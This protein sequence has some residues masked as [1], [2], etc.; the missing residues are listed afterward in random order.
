M[1]FEDYPMILTPKE[2][3]DILN[4]SKDKVYRLFRSRSFLLRKSRNVHNPKAKISEM[5]RKGGISVNRKLLHRLFRRKKHIRV[6][7]IVTKSKPSKSNAVIG[8]F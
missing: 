4:W 2:V 6:D 3:Q 1:L 5:V 7:L 8:G